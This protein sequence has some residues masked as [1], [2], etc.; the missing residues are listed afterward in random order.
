MADDVFLEDLT[1][2]TYGEIVQ[3]GRYSYRA[4]V[5]Q[6]DEILGQ[7][8][9]R[10]PHAHVPWLPLPPCDALPAFV[11]RYRRNFGEHLLKYLGAFIPRSIRSRLGLAM[12]KAW[13]WTPRR[14]QFVLQPVL[15]QVKLALKQSQTREPR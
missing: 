3:S 5:R 13:I 1:E 11:R 12:T 2:R 9:P 10:R 15:R 8:L 4:F 14:I 6:F 7:A